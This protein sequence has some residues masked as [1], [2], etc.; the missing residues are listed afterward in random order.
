M[1]P[2]LAEIVSWV[3]PEQI[4]S[5]FSFNERVNAF[6]VVKKCPHQQAHFASSA[7]SLLIAS[8]ADIGANT[9]AGVTIVSQIPISAGLRAG[10]AG[11]DSLGI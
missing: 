1:Q 9:R 11:V 4:I 3:V 10:V 6:V 7:G 8:V 5:W 2:I